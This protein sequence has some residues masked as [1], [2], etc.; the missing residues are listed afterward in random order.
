MKLSRSCVGA[1]GVPSASIW[2]YKLVTGLL[3]R[4]IEEGKVNVQT[5][6]A[7][8]SIDDITGD[9][10]A[11]VHTERGTIKARHIVHASP[12]P[13]LATFHLTRAW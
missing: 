7:V 2:P 9:E 10:F 5:H 4:L 6:T 12:A 13:G 8:R 11:A 3:G 1:I